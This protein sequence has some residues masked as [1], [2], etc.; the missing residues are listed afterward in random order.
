M[1]TND[2]IDVTSFFTDKL[3][4]ASVEPPASI[5]E[6]VKNEIPTYP[7]KIGNWY[8]YL[9][10]IMVIAVFTWFGIVKTKPNQPIIAKQIQQKTGTVDFSRKVI[11]HVSNVS[12]NSTVMYQ[13]KNN[14]TMFP[15]SIKKQEKVETS[16]YQLEASVYPSLAKV[17]F[18][19]STNTTIK[20]VSNP[21]VNEFGYYVIDI[22]SLKHGKYTIHILC[23]DGKKYS[24]QENLR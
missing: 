12:T 13:K 22:S 20:S 21:V 4:H 15:S 19:D 23:K 6:N 1:N 11:N 10:A 16:L 5:W 3:N 17:E 9:S 8:I 18:I 7:K 14:P 2:S 24:K